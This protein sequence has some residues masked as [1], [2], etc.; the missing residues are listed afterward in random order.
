M[1]GIA[2]LGWADLNN[3][4]VE[5]D[6]MPM[7][8]G[9]LASLDAAPLRDAAGRV[10]L[11]DIRAHLAARIEGVPEM[12][13]VLYRPGFLRGRPLWIDD[14]RFCIEDHVLSSTLPAPGGEKAALAFASREMSSLMDR[15]VPLWRLWLL[16]GYSNDRIGTSQSP[17]RRCRTTTV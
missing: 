5:A 12:R 2:R 16:D 10:R 13:R 9:V 11:A 14:P 3:L 8:Q 17:S 4:S 7:H 1:A 6:D 15:S